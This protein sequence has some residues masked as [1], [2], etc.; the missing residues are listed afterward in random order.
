MAKSQKL[1]SSKKNPSPSL[2]IPAILPSWFVL[3][4]FATITLLFFREQIFGGMFFWEDFTERAFPLRVFA[5]NHISSFEVPYWNPYTFCG[6]PFFA[7]PETGIFYPLNLIYDLFFSPK[8]NI[9]SFHLL[10]IIH[11]FIAQV[12][13]Y[14]LCRH[15]KISQYG[16][17]IA[18]VSFAFSATL[19]F[20]VIHPMILYNLAWFPLVLKYFDSGITTFRHR[21]ST[22]CGIILGLSILSG[23]AQ[24][25]LYEF[26]YLGLFSLWTLGA[27]Q[28][29]NNDNKIN[30]LRLIT[31]I[32]LPFIIAGG[33]FA[34]QYLPSKELAAFSERK[35]ISYT[36]ATVGSMQLPQIFTAVIPKLFGITEASDKISVSPETIPYYLESAHNSMINPYDYWET[37]F[38]FGIAALVLGLLGAS[39]IFKTRLGAFLIFTVI[40]GFLFAFGSYGFLFSFFYK[41]PLFGQLRVPSRI[42]FFVSLSMCTL[43]GFGF[44]SLWKSER[45]KLGLWKL[46]SI[47]SIPLLIA[48]MGMTGTLPAFVGA[49][50]EFIEPLSKLG[51]S[52]FLM[53]ILVFLVVFLLERRTISPLVGALALVLIIV[54]DLNA[55]NGSFKNSTVNPVD[56]YTVSPELKNLLKS[57]APNDI[58]R[59]SARVNSATAM[60][61]NQG[62]VDSIMLYEGFNALLLKRRNP[63]AS[64]EQHIKDLLNIRYQLVMDSVSGQAVFK[65]RPTHFKRAWM[66][67]DAIVS[68]SAQVHKIM[69]SSSIDITKTVVLEE[70]PRNKLSG[71]H[72]SQVQHEVKCLE[73]HNNSFK[74]SVTTAEPGVLVL[75]ELYYPDW[76][77]Y[78]D[79]TPVR[80]IPAYH[81]LRAID[82][83]AG[84]HIVEMRYESKSFTTGAIISVTTLSLALIT[85]AA[86][87][88]NRKRMNV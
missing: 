31:S 4:L 57:K 34:I 81:A 75:S 62:L 78:V 59:V 29:N 66:A 22:I 6:M 72:A 69:N 55:H 54:L 3:I 64:N 16:S 32:A 58:F 60:K 36:E 76:Q 11:F 20:R 2:N 25:A 33:I 1:T 48:I 24:T 35:E 56:K 70:S 37:S 82:V 86:S 52:A 49:Q 28:K 12:A 41:I 43:A 46:C 7:D 61:R 50:P 30:Y 53:V 51:R 63:P 67:Y 74:Y 10:V 21:D 44:D 17:I 39:S 87:G 83:P 19:A 73:Y 77:A 9:L 45:E 26:L 15:F 18:A 71:H 80:T 47:V 84:N 40:F 23:H 38:Y 88:K 68:D 13:L 14:I 27:F 85:V 5:A 79:G 42:L 8:S 65:E